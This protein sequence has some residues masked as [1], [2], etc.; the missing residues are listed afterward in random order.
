MKSSID[1]LLKSLKRA[2]PLEKDLVTR[3]WKFS[4][5]A[6]TPQK[7]ESGEPY[8]TH[9]AE[10]A[11]T[12]ANLGADAATIT[13]G[14]LHDTIEDTGKTIE[15]IR[16]DFGLEVA[17]LVDGVTKLGKLKYRG[18]KRHVESLR[19]LFI[20]TAEDPRVILIKLADR[21]HNMQTLKAL[22]EEK[23]MRIALETLEIYAPIAH[24]LGIGKMKGELEDLAFQAAYQEAFMETRKARDEKASRAEDELKKMVLKIGTLLRGVGIS[25]HSIDTRIKH[26]YSLH[27]KLQEKNA[28]IENIY[29]IAALRVIVGTVE[30]CYLVLGLIHS[31]WK[32]LPGRIKDYIAIPKANGYRS[33]HTTVFTGTGSVVEI[34]IRTQEMHDIAEHGIASHVSYKEHTN[35]SSSFALAQKLMKG[36]L[37]VSSGSDSPRWIRDLAE[38]HKEEQHSQ[39]FIKNLK[40]DVLGDRIFVFTPRGEVVDLPVDAS[41][42][43][44]AYSIHTD[45]GNHAAGAR[46]NGKFMALNTKLKHGDIVEIETKESSH[47]S[48]KWLAWVKT[49]F[50]KKKIRIAVENQKK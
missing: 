50:A 8:F 14:L 40:V 26:L 24:R 37:D 6:H 47:P 45:L 20:A 28:N 25:A 33:L 1:T 41:P 11:L 21:L 9:V 19:K 7:R 17:F 35:S 3:A 31:T 48:A 2:S 38:T 16:N 5:E 36:P 12:L 18:L 13:A 29:D 34:Q 15:D 22:P 49:S 43:D 44:F 32:P 23:R 39:S 30:E 46:I 42:I 4:E 10:T 27:K